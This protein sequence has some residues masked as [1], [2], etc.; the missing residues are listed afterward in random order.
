MRTWAADAEGVTQITCVSAHTGNYP[1]TSFPL[2]KNNKSERRVVFDHLERARCMMAG[3]EVAAA[4]VSFIGFAFQ[5]FQG[6]VQ[7]LEFFE[8]TQN[9]GSDGDLL[10]TGLE[11]QKYRLI[12][13]AER[14]GL[15]KTER[16]AVNWQ[17]ARLVLEQLLVMLTSAEKLK[18]RYHLEVSEETLETAEKLRNAESP[19]QGIAKLIA[20]L[21]P[22]IQT[23][24]GRIIQESNSTVKRLRWATRDKTKLK[25]Y[26]DEIKNLVDNLDILLDHAERESDR[27]DME[28][29]LRGLVSFIPSTAEA[30]QIEEL[31]GA[32]RHH[33]HAS[34]EAIKAAAY[35]K[36][37]RLVVGADKREDEETPSFRKAPSFMPTLR[38][39]KHR[40]LRSKAGGELREAGLELGLYQDAP[41]LVQWKIAEGPEWTKFEQQMKS[42]T[43]LLMS[44]VH[45]SFHSLPCLGLVSV[46]EKGRYGLVFVLPTDSLDLQVT[47]LDE[48]VKTAQRVSLARRLEISRNIAEAVLQL[49]TAGWMHKSLRPA[50]VVFLA[51]QGAKP[52]QILQTTPYIVGY[53]YARPD[54]LDA[55]K[56]FTQLPESSLRSE[57]Y[58]HPQARGADRQTYQKRFDMY[59]LGCLVVELMA[60]KSLADLHSEH[61]DQGFRGKLEQAESTNGV[62]EVPSLDE[63]MGKQ[64]A[65]DD[66]EHQAGAQVV[67]AVR[68]CLGMKQV[69]G[70]EDAGLEDQMAVIEML[71]WCRV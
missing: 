39:L 69:E 21:R 71:S 53:D 2:P 1:A 44:L 62:T 9:I 31:V 63:L 38:K 55:A 46:K 59:A 18:T 34:E 48:L 17:Y 43:V 67:K 45:E 35:V 4:G 7:A 15:G 68:R 57:L 52:E 32:G 54:T 26:L 12:K 8:T 50:N 51:K 3:L 61:T 64:G 37:V 19:K 25:Q 40:Y 41:V 22:T 56:A 66:L 33:R 47:G 30:E 13:W 16:P 60:W 14:S 28:K 70:T 11:I 36:Q 27:D 5:S 20:R 49:H 29:L 10:R 6:C 23:A 65:V 24:A 58:R 42:L